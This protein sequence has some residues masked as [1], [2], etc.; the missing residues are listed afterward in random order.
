MI[1][2][3]FLEILTQK[4]HLNDI[5]KEDYQKFK[6]KV[7]SYKSPVNLKLKNNVPL[8]QQ[9]LIIIYISKRNR[10]GSPLNCS[11]S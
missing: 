9:M 11:F 3:F 10:Y 8:N 1:N 2:F 6:V 4:K 5:F 7:I